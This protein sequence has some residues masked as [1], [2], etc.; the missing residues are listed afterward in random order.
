MRFAMHEQESGGMTRF[1]NIGID[2]DWRWTQGSI[3]LGSRCRKKAAR[4]SDM[5]SKDSTLPTIVHGWV[6]TQTFNQKSPVRSMASF[7]IHKRDA[8]NA[9]LNT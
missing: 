6:F 4:L 8:G 9:I 7:N 3:G 2:R 5:L 1:R